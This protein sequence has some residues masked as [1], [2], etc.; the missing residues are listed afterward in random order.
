[1]GRREPGACRAGVRGALVAAREVGGDQVVT[2]GV[3]TGSR[4]P[5]DWTE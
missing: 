1:M 3:G 4:R 2:G 5:E